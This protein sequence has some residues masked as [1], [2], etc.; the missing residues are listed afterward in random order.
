MARLSRL[1]GQPLEDGLLHLDGIRLYS[2]EAAPLPAR[3]SGPLAPE[4]EFSLT[5][6]L[7]E[8]ESLAPFRDADPSLEEV[9]FAG[10]SALRIPTPAQSWDLVVHA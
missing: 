3:S 1:I 10:R 6:V 7:L 5:A 4:K 8:A 2:R 9:D